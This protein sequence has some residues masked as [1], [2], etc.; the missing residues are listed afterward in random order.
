MKPLSSLTSARAIE[1]V[2][3]D[4]DDTLLDRGALS[5][6]AYGALFAMRAAGL[7]LVACTGRPAGWARLVAEWWP[8]DAA[9]A[10]NGAFAWV[11]WRATKSTIE[12]LVAPPR[13]TP[14]RACA[15]PGA[16]SARTSLLDL[17]REL[18]A[19]HPETA[20]ADDN[21]ARRT[22][23]TI[24]VGEVRAA[25]EATVRSLVQAARSGGARTFASSVHVHLTH[26]PDD[27]ATGSLRLLQELFGLDPTAARHRWA[28]VGDSGND[29]AAFAAFDTTFGVANVRAHAGSLSLPPRYVTDRPRGDGFAELARHVVALRS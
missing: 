4:L 18:V 9:I 27:K 15:R 16:G 21:D 3:F 20:L 14:P 1:G 19:S 22:D 24:D 10:E 25:S 13:A 2:L 6:Q 28:F 17:A 11:S 5:A 7:R 26:E 8:I 29:A 12:G 23:V